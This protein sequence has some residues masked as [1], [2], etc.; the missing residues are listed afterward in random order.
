M[1][2]L[3][4]KTRLVTGY[5][6]AR[7]GE[8]VGESYDALYPGIPAENEA[9]IKLLADLALEHPATSLLEFG[10]G[11]GRL[12]LGI[13]RRGVRVAGIE[14]SERMLSQLR[15]K[16]DAK[17]LTTVVGDYRD[18]RVKGAFSVVVLALNGIFD[19]RG[20]RVQLDIFRNAAWHLAVGGYFVVESWVMHD[21]QRNGEWSVFPRYVGEE[22]V[23]LQLARYDIDT[24]KIERTLVH[25]LPEGMKFVTVTDTYASP[26]ELDVMAEV[27]KFDR[28]ARYSSWNR[29]EFTSA[30]TQSVSIYQL[31][32]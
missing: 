23:E 6:P 8:V 27:T 5:N 29:S 3:E 10:I 32:S 9:A 2:S 1:S 4:A 25:L 24:N 7:Y 26:G 18:A 28:V 11:T 17:T 16:L 31:R 13:A 20:P 19:P 14:G 12:A 21:A 30:S 22:H 15:E